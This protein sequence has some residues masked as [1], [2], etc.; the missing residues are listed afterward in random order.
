SASTLEPTFMAVWNQQ[1]PALRGK[2]K[3]TTGMLGSGH[4]QFDLQAIP[5]KNRRLFSEPDGF[6]VVGEKG[7]LDPSWAREAAK[8]LGLAGSTAFRKFL[9]SFGAD[10][11]D[12][13]AA[14]EGLSETFGLLSRSSH[15]RRAQPVYECIIRYFDK[16]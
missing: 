15:D 14:F 9:K 11:N 13:R 4:W 6:L 8:D 3:F 1:W 2:F 12:G 5:Q 16:S 10:F 7:D